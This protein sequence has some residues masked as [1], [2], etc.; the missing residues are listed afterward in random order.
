MTPPGARL[1]NLLDGPK[2]KRE[3]KTECKQGHWHAPGQRCKV[4][5]KLAFERFKAKGHLTCG[6]E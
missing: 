1:V 2:V 3:L 6:S 4:C 5:M